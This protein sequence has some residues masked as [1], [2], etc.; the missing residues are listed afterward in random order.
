MSTM[1]NK[2]LIIL[3]CLLVLSIP[4]GLYL[5]HSLEIKSA[6]LTLSILIGPVII[7]SGV[8]FR[9]LNYQLGL[10]YKAIPGVVGG[11]LSFGRWLSK[12]RLS[13]KIQG[14]QCDLFYSNGNYYQ[15]SLTTLRV[16]IEA[17]NTLRVYADHWALKCSNRLFSRIP[18][19][20]IGD[21]QFD[22]FFIA[23]SLDADFVKA[24]ISGDALIYTKKIMRLVNEIKIDDDQFCYSIGGIWPNKDDFRC[25][26]KSVTACIC[27]ILA[28]KK[29]R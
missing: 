27:N 16:N 19:V 10:S 17:S 20:K 6:P 14:F 18:V 24:I 29:G 23:E 13:F 25:L 1:S 21:D 11:Q 28:Y 8:F 9:F 2:R 22:K 26:I 7:A 5:E 15:G 4:L 3:L 12:P